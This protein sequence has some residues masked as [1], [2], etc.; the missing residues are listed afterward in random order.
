MGH[1]RFLAAFLA[2]VLVACGPDALDQA[3]GAAATGGATTTG[4]GGGASGVGG[5]GGGAGGT[6]LDELLAALRA[7]RDAALLAQSRGDGWPAPV[8]GGHLVVST[9][10]ALDEVAGDHDGWRGAPLTADDGFAWAVVSFTP[11]DAYKLKGGNTFVADRWSR[12]YDYDDFGEKSLVAPTASHLDRFF[13]VGD[14]AMAPRTV[15]VWVPGEAASHVIYVADGQNLFAPDAPWGGWKLQASAPPGMLLVGID[16]TAARMDEYTHVPDVIGGNTVGGEGD[17][18]ADFVQIT[19]R[20]LVAETYG[21]PPVVGAMGSSLGGLVSFHLALR[22]PGA[23][24]FAASLSGT[25]GWGS[26]GAGVHNETMIERYA[27]AG[28]G[29]TALYLDSGGGGSC[30]DADQD[31]IEDDDPTASDNFCENA[32]LETVLVAAG[33]VHAVDL[34]HWHEPGAP[35]KESAW[36]ARVWRPLQIFA[37]R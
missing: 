35:H 22:H 13:A 5:G 37:A 14:A 15:R 26:I 20:G 30:F 36:A 6:S 4:A 8:E 18:Y 9:D 21:E 23:Y 11:G 25:M 24:D 28:H 17:A 12:A 7:D 10:P 16:N 19:V 27:A 29:S 34:W 32:Q 2:L 3:P 1:R 33:Y 31:G